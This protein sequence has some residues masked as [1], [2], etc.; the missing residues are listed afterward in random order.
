MLFSP[1]LLQTEA[2]APAGRPQAAPAPVGPV[3]RWVAPAPRFRPVVV[4]PGG[5]RGALGGLGE[6]LGGLREA[7]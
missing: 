6:A 5:L 4:R 7:P 2:A 3:C 1:R